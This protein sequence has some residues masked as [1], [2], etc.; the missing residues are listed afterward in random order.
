VTS[1]AGADSANIGSPPITAWQIANTYETGTEVIRS[2]SF[3]VNRGEVISVVGPSGC[4][5]TTL[6]N[7]L[8]G[9]LSLSHGTVMWYGREIDGVPPG[10]GYM[11]QKDLLFPWRTAYENA[12]LGLQLKGLGRKQRREVVMALLGRLGLAEFADYYPSALSG[13]MRQRVALAR[14]FAGDPQVLLLD[15]PF[16]ALDFQTK[17]LIESDTAK[18]VREQGRSLLLITHDVEEAV[19]LSDRV[20][21]LSHR[22]CTVVAEHVIEFDG[23]RSDIMAMREHPE[24]YHHVR[25]IW[26]ELD[27]R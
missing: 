2:I 4:G 16:S 24:F 10:A 25:G 11:L 1:N 5:K 17:I 15:E 12:A 13:G 21:V 3:S 6:L 8:C 9:L 23:D 27:I 19:S 20:I 18:L 7:M 22:P 14:T 26:N